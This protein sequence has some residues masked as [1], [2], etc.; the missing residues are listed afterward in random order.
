MH[1]VLPPGAIYMLCSYRVT[2]NTPAHGTEFEGMRAAEQRRPCLRLLA[3]AQP[4]CH[5]QLLFASR[6]V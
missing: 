4:R 6:G 5:A 1:V 3:Y 2:L